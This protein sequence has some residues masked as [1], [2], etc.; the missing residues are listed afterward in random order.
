MEK[1]KIKLA[2]NNTPSLIFKEIP[3]P[4]NSIN[5]KGNEII[6]KKKNV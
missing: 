3:K 1:D 2:D 4:Q 6:S 5:A